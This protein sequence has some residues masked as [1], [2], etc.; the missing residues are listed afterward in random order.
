[1]RIRFLTLI[2]IFS[3]VFLFSQVI[4]V[5][6]EN[7]NIYEYLDEL[8]NQ[9]VITLHSQVKPW[10]RAMIAEK[11]KEALIKEDQ[12][13]PR[14]KKELS[15]YLKDYNLEGKQDL[16]Y[17]KTGKGTFKHTNSFGIPLNPLA[18]L[19]KDSLFTFSLRPILGF[20]YFANNH[21]KPYHYWNGAEIFGNVGKHV[22][23]YASLRDNHE[24]QVMVLPGYITQDEGAV[25]KLSG[26]GGDYSEMRGGLTYAWNRGSV[27]LVKDHFVWGENYHGSNIFSGRTPSFPYFEL[28]M[29]PVPW[30]RLNYIT[31]WI[32]SDIVDSSSSYHYPGGI[33][34][35]YFS[36]FLSAALF[37]FTPWKGLDLSI[38]NSVISCSRS[39]NPAFL[40]PMLFYVN[41]NNSGDS[42]EKK[43]YGQNSQFFFSLNSRQIKHV[44][45][46]ASLFIDGT[47]PTNSNGYSGSSGIS[48]KAGFRVS[49][50]PVQNL[51]FT[52]EYTRSSQ[53][54]Y[55]CNVATLTFASNEYNLGSYLMDNAQE[56][57]LA[58]SYKPCRG[59]HITADY[60]FAQHG[61]NKV[62]QTL[63]NIVWK[64]QAIT[65][66]I[67]YEIINNA[68]AFIQYEYSNITGDAGFTPPVF[69]G[70]VTGL[71]T[72]INIGF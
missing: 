42:L 53:N 25:W 58:V 18:F 27:S 2:F 59:L 67:K 51:S 29:N 68:Y 70:N 16:S 15:F 72:G 39:Y 4:Y 10:S 54:V 22:G 28:R 57:Y 71:A 32:N 64:K 14:Q 12:L 35:A 63:G 60:V 13:N 45:L 52:G 62:T 19:Y 3:P 55:L 1:M 44:N 31:C 9:Q 65:V 33:R 56:L 61:D 6:I 21:G 49:N 41:F 69:L 40:C 7:V 48:G 20:K 66:G 23:L 26:A 43:Q 37:T 34:S 46:F 38:G 50:F 8:A 5:G 36:K 17:F 47:G 24:N 30:F 11:L